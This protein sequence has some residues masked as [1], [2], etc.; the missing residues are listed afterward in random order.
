MWT[1]LA[2]LLIFLPQT[3]FTLYCLLTCLYAFFK[4]KCVFDLY[5][6]CL[7]PSRRTVGLLNIETIEEMVD[8]LIQVY[9][10]KK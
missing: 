1:S 3:L 5:S 2:G 10:N 4:D 9:S 7:A 8:F 6:Q